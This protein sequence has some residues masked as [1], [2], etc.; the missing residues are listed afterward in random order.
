MLFV[1]YFPPNFHSPRETTLVGV[2][3]MQDAALNYAAKLENAQ[4]AEVEG[5]WDCFK[6][7]NMALMTK[8]YNEEQKEQ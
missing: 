2:F 7:I 8:L 3:L 6:K 5:T 1:V 4:V